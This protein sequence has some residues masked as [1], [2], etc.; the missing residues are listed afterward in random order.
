MKY[1]SKAKAKLAIRIKGYES[2]SAADKAAYTKPG[3]MRK[4]QT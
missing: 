4:K 2:L 1:L 3:S